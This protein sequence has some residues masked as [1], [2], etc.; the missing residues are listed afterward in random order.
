MI[1]PSRVSPAALEQLRVSAGASLFTSAHLV[2]R[3]PLRVVALTGL[4]VATD[5]RRTTDYVGDFARFAQTLGAERA[6]AA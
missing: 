5:P 4:Q 2:R 6:L 3:E 1:E